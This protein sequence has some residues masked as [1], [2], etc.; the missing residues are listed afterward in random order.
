MSSSPWP[1][2][3]SQPGG[4]GHANGMASRPHHWYCFQLSSGS[5]LPPSPGLSYSS[6]NVTSVRPARAAG[7]L[8]FRLLLPRTP[9]QRAG[10]A[11]RRERRG[12]GEG[13]RRGAQQRTEG[14]EG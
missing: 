10:R 5:R 1:S 9:L 4:S 7:M 2:H 8:P 3:W 13:A 12:G 11:S 6:K 14:G